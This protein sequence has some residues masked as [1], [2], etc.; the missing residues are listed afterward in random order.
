MTPAAPTTTTTTQ[1]AHANAA[2]LAFTGADL[3][4]LVG[5]GVLFLTAGALVLFYARRRTRLNH[6]APRPDRCH[7]DPGAPGRSATLAY[8]YFTSTG[9]GTGSAAT[10]SLA[11]PVIASATPGAGTV[12]LNW[13]P[14]V[15]PPGAPA[16]TYYVTADG[17]TPREPAPPRLRPPLRPVA[18][19]P[20]SGREPLLYGHRGMADLHRD[21]H[22]DQC[23]RHLGA[24]TQLAFTTQPVG[25]VAEGINFA[26]QPKVSVEDSAGNVVTGDTGP[27]T[28]SIATYTAGN[29]GIAQGTLGCTNL[30]VNAVAGVATFAGCN[31]T[32]T[33]AAGTYTLNAARTGLTTA[34]SGNVSVLASWPASWPSPSNRATAPRAPRSS[35][36][37]SSTSW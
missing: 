8:A 17:G 25:G 6:E 31:I 35:P 22:Y 16:V 27:V 11:K 13:A 29:G 2:S 33:A 19:T 21:E 28:L 7:F 37:R 14:G 36:S 4:L 23:D 1:P 9:V 20:D 32:G 18:P 34:T 12:A 30:T 3:A 15:T 5:G 24:A 26:T 10:G